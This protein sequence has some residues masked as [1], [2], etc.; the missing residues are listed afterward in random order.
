[1]IK[2]AVIGMGKMGLLHSSTLCGFNDVKFI[3][4]AD[5]NK[6]N[7]PSSIKKDNTNPPSNSAP[8]NS[9]VPVSNPAQPVASIPAATL[10]TVDPLLD[11]RSG[12]PERRVVNLIYQKCLN[13]P[14]ELS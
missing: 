8:S 6:S 3:G 14:S 2:A 10:P 12:S 13:E 7:Q 9:S 1:M 5:D 11:P 4:F